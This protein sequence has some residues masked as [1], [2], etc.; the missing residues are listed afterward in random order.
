MAG[1]FS[2]LTG[3]LLFAGLALATGAAIARWTILP[4]V[5]FDSEQPS[6]EWLRTGAARVGAVGA[7]LLPLALAFYFARQ[8]QE[9]RD[10]FVPWTE[11]ASLL[12][13]ATS[14][15]RSWLWAAGG[16]IVAVAAMFL[17]RAG[18]SA[19]WWLVTPVMLA[20]CAFPGLTGH[21]A[22]TEGLGLLPIAADTMHVWAAG[23][24]MGGLAL[25]LY[26]ERR[27]RQ[28]VD[29]VGS[30]LPVLVPAFSRIAMVCVGAL[31]V[32]G[33]FAAWTQLA[34]WTS[35]VTTGYGRTLLL[36]LAVV[37]VVMALGGWNFRVLTPRLGDA[38]G[39]MAMRRT[40]SVELLIAQV[41]LLITAILVRSSPLDH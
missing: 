11:D 40:A 14:W 27:W 2:A 3:W 23:G 16:S 37:A 20:L 25:V 7:M 36:K 18:Y 5:R 38:S 32:T 24:W 1:T 29:P 8:L 10:P 12:L 22:G 21:A 17:A 31:I 13:G 6:S 34:D 35:L 19:G 33:S 26:L 28:E 41:V 4:R 9:F 15:G 39:S 30:L